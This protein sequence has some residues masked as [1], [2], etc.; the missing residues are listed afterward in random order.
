MVTKKGRK[1]TGRKYIKQRKKKKYEIAG[2][3]RT[4][5]LGEEKKKSKR[6]CGGNKKNIFN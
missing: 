5:K 3:K 6:I 2:Q 4:V 1:I